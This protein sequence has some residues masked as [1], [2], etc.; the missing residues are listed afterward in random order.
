MVNGLQ[1]AM[2]GSIVEPQSVP[3]ADSETLAALARLRQAVDAR[4]AP[5]VAEQNAKS[6]IPRS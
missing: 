6:G 3:M 2:P 1:R 4:D 5:R